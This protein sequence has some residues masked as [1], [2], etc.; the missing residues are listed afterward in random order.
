MKL[1]LKAKQ[2]GYSGYFK[3]IKCRKSFYLSKQQVQET[4]DCICQKCIKKTKTLKLR[5]IEQQQQYEITLFLLYAIGL[6]M[7]LPFKLSKISKPTKI[8]KI[9]KGHRKKQ[10]PQIKI[11]RKELL[12]TRGNKCEYC[13]QIVTNITKLHMHHIDRNRDNNTSDNLLLLCNFCHAKQHLDNFWV[14][15]ILKKT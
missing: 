1:F 4:K 7:W 10:N 15:N 2:F 6:R 5:E 13:E 9:K 14:Y 11:K 12:Q 8:Y 3:C